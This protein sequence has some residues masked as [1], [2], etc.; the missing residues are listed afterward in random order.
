MQS[1]GARVLRPSDGR[2]GLLGSMGVRFML[3][4]KETGGG[5][6][7]V[8]W[9]VPR[10]IEAS[11][12]SV[13]FRD[14]RRACSS[15]TELVCAPATAYSDSHDQPARRVWRG[16]LGCGYDACVKCAKRE[17]R[18]PDRG[19]LRC[20][21]APKG[22]AS[23][24]AHR[25][26]G[27]HARC[28]VDPQ[29]RVDRRKAVQ[30]HATGV[31]KPDSALLVRRAGQRARQAPDDRARGGTRR[32]ANADVAELQGLAS[33]LKAHTR[34]FWVPGMAPRRALGSG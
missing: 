11:Q 28:W 2:V 23:V 24:R 8:D 31:E 26:R 20:T 10:P 19:D 22:G 17:P 14:P 32:C 1:E 18:R 6:P 16:D 4:G 12:N 3:A 15:R 5:Q 7:S 34:A 25:P 9:P 29:Q 33:A 30:K 27:I 13:L 21:P